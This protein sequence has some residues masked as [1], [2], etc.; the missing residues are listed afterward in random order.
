[1]PPNPTKETADTRWYFWHG[2]T[3]RDTAR[4]GIVLD[5][6]LLLIV[7]HC[8]YLCV[9]LTTIPCTIEATSQIVN[10]I[11]RPITRESRRF[12]WR[13]NCRQF[14]CFSDTCGGVS[15]ST[16]RS[17]QLPLSEAIS[18]PLCTT[19]V[20]QGMGFLIA[21]CAIQAPSASAT[22]SRTVSIGSSLSIRT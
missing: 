15:D 9:Q 12:R 16:N 13:L 2:L 5:Q 18:S 4:T 3:A 22:N 21:W 8:Q 11:S 19:R 7:D 14:L 10:V 1:M 17:H 20:L 6:S